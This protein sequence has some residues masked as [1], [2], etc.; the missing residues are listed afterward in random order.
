MKP[1]D[2]AVLALEADRL[3][4]QAGALI[5]DDGIPRKASRL[6][7]KAVRLYREAARLSPDPERTRLF[8][9]AAEVAEFDGLQ[10]TILA[11]VREACQGD[12]TSEQEQELRDHWNAWMWR[13]EPFPEIAPRGSKTLMD[14]RGPLSGQMS[15][16]GIDDG[17]KRK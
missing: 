8:L 12:P 9:R 13:E 3:C 16:P 4:D 17:R 2:P 7:G 6:A 11:V 15:M 14:R 1:D 5:T 10:N